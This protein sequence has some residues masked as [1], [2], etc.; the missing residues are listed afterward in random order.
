MAKFKVASP[1]AHNGKD[2]AVGAEIEIDD[3]AQVAALVAAGAI[4]VLAP[5]GKTKEAEAK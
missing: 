5:K 2:Y 4:D 3:K 1:I